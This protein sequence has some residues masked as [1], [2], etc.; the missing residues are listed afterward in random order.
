MSDVAQQLAD[1]Y[2]A[3]LNKV[4]SVS[5]TRMR[6]ARSPATPLTARPILRP[7]AVWI[8][9][10]LM[11]AVGLGALLLFSFM[12]PKN[13]VV[14]QPRVKYSEDGKQ[15]PKIDK[16]VFSWCVSWLGKERGS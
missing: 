16:G 2:Q 13:S 10:G 11:S 12:R 14:Y 6:G 4:G 3:R 8:Q 1:A 5:P 15:P 7:Q 9:L